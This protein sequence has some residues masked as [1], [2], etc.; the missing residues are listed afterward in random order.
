MESLI[1]QHFGHTCPIQFLFNSA[2]L[3]TVGNYHVL[4]YGSTHFLT[5]YAL[6][7]L[8]GSLFTG[9]DLYSNEKGYYAGA[10]APS[11]GLIAYHVFKNP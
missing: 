11:A 10:I 8:G 6:A 9:V 2:L 7:A 5:L 4:A 3:Y 1:W